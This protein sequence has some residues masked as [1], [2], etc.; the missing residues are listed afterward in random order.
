MDQTD[1]KTP[2]D[3]NT[4]LIKKTIAQIK[5]NKEIMICKADKGN[6]TVMMDTKE[7]ITK[8]NNTINSFP[9][10]KLDRNPNSN[11]EKVLKTSLNQLM[12]FNKISKNTHQ[13]LNPYQSICPR[14]YGSPKIHKSGYPLRPIVDYSKSPSYANAPFLNQLLV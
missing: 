14:F 13:Y 4:Q 8:V 10:K 12:N 3:K 6:M 9:Y 7:Y 5:K 11:Y 2:D 1:W